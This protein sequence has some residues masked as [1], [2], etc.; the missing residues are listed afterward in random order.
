MHCEINQIIRNV[1]SWRAC[2]SEVCKILLTFGVS[3]RID[4]SSTSQKD[5]FVEKSYDIGAWLM[6]SKDDGSLI[7]LCKINEGFDNVVGV[8]RIETTGW[9]VQKQDRR[10]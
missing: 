1:E 7:R 3:S 9:L 6:D 2:I 4:Y 8:E 5:K 10:A